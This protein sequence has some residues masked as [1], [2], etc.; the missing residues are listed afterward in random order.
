MSRA[1]LTFAS[2]LRKN[3]DCVKVRR[4][5]NAFHDNVDS[6]PDVLLSS[7]KVRD[8]FTLDNPYKQQLFQE[9]YLDYFKTKILAN[10]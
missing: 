8:Y 2:Y 6:L 5:M 1:S 7:K 4:F 3:L 10:Y 9:V